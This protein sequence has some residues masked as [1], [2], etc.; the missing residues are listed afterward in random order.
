MAREW[1]PTP[2]LIQKMNDRK[3]TWAEVVDILDHPEVIYG[4]DNRGRRIHQKGDLSV[5]VS[6]EGA[7]IT[8]LLRQKE[9]WT[10]DEARNRT[11]V[12]K[13]LDPLIP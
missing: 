6:R 2:H 5:V 1:E 7:V 12:R 3:V 11:R 10:D 13:P 4:P 8:C 9:Q